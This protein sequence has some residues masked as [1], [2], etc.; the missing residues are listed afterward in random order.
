M[1]Y[2]IVLDNPEKL[3]DISSRFRTNHITWFIKQVKSYDNPKDFDIH[4]VFDKPD[5]MTISDICKMCNVKEA[6]LYF[7][8][9]DEWA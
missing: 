8:T 5:S 4:V 9:E 2:F 6:Y 3:I 7:N 1:Q